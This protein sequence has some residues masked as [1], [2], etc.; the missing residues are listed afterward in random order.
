MS[1]SVTGKNPAFFS[2]FEHY[3]ELLIIIVELIFNIVSSS[4]YFSFIAEFS[5]VLRYLSEDLVFLLASL[6]FVGSKV[7]PLPFDVVGID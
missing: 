1:D 5:I 4:E 7:L 3:A 6:S 2:F